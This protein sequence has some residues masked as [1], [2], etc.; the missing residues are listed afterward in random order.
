MPKKIKIKKIIRN[1][2][3]PVQVILSVNQNDAEFEK[4]L[5]KYDLSVADEPKLLLDGIKRQAGRAIKF[6]DEQS[7]VIR[8]NFYPKS[9]NKYGLLQHEIFHVTNYA[10]E[11]IGMVYSDDSA[12]AFC[13]FTQFLTNE[14]YTI[15]DKSKK[16]HLKTKKN[17]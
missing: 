4:Y 2:L 5:N 1:D 13:Y 12:E 11:Q 14:I 3:F 6:T 8:L 7:T 16:A 17:K 10:M 15:L 9:N